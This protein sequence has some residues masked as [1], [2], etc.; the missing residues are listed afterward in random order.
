MVGFQD[1]LTK[2]SLNL[3]IEG[4]M[5][6]AECQGVPRGLISGIKHH[7]EG[8]HNEELDFLYCSWIS[9]LI[10]IVWP[11]KFSNCWIN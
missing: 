7:E 5:P 1:L 11:V 2:L 3:R 6:E 4:E 10:K 9:I 8:R